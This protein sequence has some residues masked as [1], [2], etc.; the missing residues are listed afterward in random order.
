MPKL[1]T[2]TLQAEKKAGSVDRNSEPEPLLGLLASLPRPRVGL[3]DSLS[4]DASSCHKPPSAIILSSAE[5]AIAARR[6]R[7]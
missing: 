4:S 7:S 6:I 3:A 1:S 2:P 5:R